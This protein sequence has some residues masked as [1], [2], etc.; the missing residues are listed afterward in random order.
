MMGNVTG[1]FAFFGL[2]VTVLVPAVVWIMLLVGLWQFA[3]EE[4][5]QIRVILP[6]RAELAQGPASH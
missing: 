1:I 5:R 3:R 2:A 6:G 4:I